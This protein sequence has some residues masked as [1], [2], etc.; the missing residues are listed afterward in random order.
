[1]R[2]LLDTNVVILILRKQL[3]A[4]PTAMQRALAAEEAV[5]FVSVASMWEIAIKA[6]LGKLDVGAP[7]QRLPYLCRRL[8]A[9]ILAIETRH[10]LAEPD[11]V[12]ATRDP[13]DRLLLAQAGVEGLRLLTL[14]RALARHPLAWREQA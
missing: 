7:L 11:P 4:M 1:M 14:D 2:I 8:P 3:D 13:F 6:R 9:T 5:L 10:V 12:P